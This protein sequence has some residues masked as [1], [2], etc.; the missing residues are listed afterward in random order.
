MKFGIIG[1]GNIAHAF[2]KGCAASKNGELYAVASRDMN[3]SK[4][5]A[6]KYNVKKAY[7]NYTSLLEDKDVEAIYIATPHPMHHKWAIAVAKAKKHILC[8]KPAAMN[9]KELKEMIDTAKENKVFFMEAFMY[10]SHPQTQKVIELIK[11]GVIGEIRNI[12]ASFGYNFPEDGDIERVF[13]KELGGG[14]IL[15]VG[16]Y[17]ISYIRMLASTQAEKQLEPVEFYSVGK[18]GTT[19]VDNYTNAILKFENDITAF[20]TCSVSCDAQNDVKIFGSKGNMWIKSP[21]VCDVSKYSPAIVV[22][23]NG[24]DTKYCIKARNLYSYEIDT[25]VKYAKDGEAPTM[26]HADSLG[27]AKVLDMWLKQL[28]IKY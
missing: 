26:N 8:E 2:A 15:D 28:G 12:Q 17:P 13:S 22:T 11:S 7:D 9:Y 19:G 16:C 25:V 24:K 4:E 3:K 10:R 18:V 6:E 20:A 21:F 1:L 27:N 14:G 5:F 23:I